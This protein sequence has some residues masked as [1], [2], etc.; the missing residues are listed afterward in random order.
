MLKSIKINPEELLYRVANSQSSGCLELSEGLVS[1]KIYFQHGNFKYAECSAQSLDQI[2]Y[3]LHYL[4]S[5]KALQALKSTPYEKIQFY[6]HEK[7]WGESLYSNVIC[8]LLAEQH[9]DVFEGSKLIECMTK[10]ALRSCLWLKTGTFLWYARE[11]VPFW[12]RERYGNCLSLSVPECLNAEKIRLKQWHNYSN[13][14][15][16]VHQRPY[17][18]S[19]WQQKPLPVSGLL[20]YQTLKKLNQ[21]M[22]G[23]TSIRQLSLLLRKDELQVAKILSPY[24]DEQII[25]LRNP[26]S[27]LDLLPN[28][29]QT[30]QN[31]EQSIPNQKRK[32]IVSI[33]DSPIILQEIQRFLPHDKYEIT[34]IDDPVQAVSRIFKID[35]DLILLDIT[36]PRINGYKLCDLLRNSGKCDDT[37][38]VMVTA[39]SGLIDKARAKMAGATDYLTKPFTQEKLLKTIQ[40]HIE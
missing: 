9:L 35:P 3:Y 34:A 38:I 1:W 19:G 24:I 39:N 16:S 22:Q 23:R 27:P 18:T 31:K 7:P 12:I 25:Y 28:I 20:N 4:G 40:K 8:W 5:Q 17:F 13:Q 14:L 10:D 11:P 29:P 36:M 2:K 37:P 30:E 6:K 15:L 26:Q 33:D 21:V 32:T